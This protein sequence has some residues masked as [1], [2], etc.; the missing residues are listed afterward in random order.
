MA[1]DL[2][3]HRWIFDVGD[4]SQ[5]TPASTAGLDINCSSPSDPHHEPAGAVVR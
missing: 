1:E 5:R 3:D 4:H 2:L